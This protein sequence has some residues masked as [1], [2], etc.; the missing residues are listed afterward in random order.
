MLQSFFFKLQQKNKRKQDKL[1]LRQEQ[2][3]YT[4]LNIATLKKK[5][6]Q[7]PKDP[8]VSTGI[9]LF[10]FFCFIVLG[11]HLTHTP[12]WKF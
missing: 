10:F 12:W 2:T 7:T 9:K 1:S 3:V 6:L 4:N 5:K 8:N 11:K